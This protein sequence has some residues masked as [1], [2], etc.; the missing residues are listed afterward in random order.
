[1]MNKSGELELLLISHT[2]DKEKNLL[3]IYNDVPKLPD[4]CNTTP[5]LFI[6]TF[7]LVHCLHNTFSKAFSAT[8]RSILVRT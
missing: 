3:C 6:Y 1:M 7:S 5:P 8:K 2:L 4:V